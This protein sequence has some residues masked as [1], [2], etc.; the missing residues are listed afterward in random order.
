MK[1]RE[2]IL[3]EIEELEARQDSLNDEQHKI[4]EQIKKLELKL[5]NLPFEGKYIKYIDVFDSTP[6]YMKVDWIRQAP[7]KADRKR[8]YSYTFKGLGFFGEFTGHDD[9]TQFNWSYWF[10][11]NITGNYY[12]F[13]QKIS[14]IEEIDKAEFD[15]AFD[16]MLKIMK[17][18][19]Y[20]IK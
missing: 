9:A 10:E 8:P 20:K 18:Y 12:D 2:K 14:K 19:H 13:K 15:E 16:L 17:E 4:S 3:K 11:F 5:I 7:E 1:D 6:I